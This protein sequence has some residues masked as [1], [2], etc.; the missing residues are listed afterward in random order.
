MRLHRFIDKGKEYT[1]PLLSGN[2]IWHVVLFMDLCKF[3]RSKVN[4]LIIHGFIVAVRYNLA[5]FPTFLTII[6]SVVAFVTTLTFVVE[7]PI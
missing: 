6:P 4:L 7:N 2:E 3:F 5:S 1:I